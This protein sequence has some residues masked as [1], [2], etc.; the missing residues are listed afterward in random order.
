MSFSLCFQQRV[1]LKALIFTIDRDSHWKLIMLSLCYGEMTPVSSSCW[2]ARFNGGGGVL[3]MNIKGPHTSS[4]PWLWRFGKWD[5]ELLGQIYSDTQC[6]GTGQYF[7]NKE[8]VLGG[9][10][11]TSTGSTPLVISPL[12]G[13]YSPP[14]LLSVLG[15][16]KC[17]KMEFTLR[18]ERSFYRPNGS[19]ATTTKF[20]RWWHNLP[21]DC[22]LV[23]K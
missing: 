15:R 22:I 5:Y 19:P 23:G 16:R 11:I 9:P 18:G 7:C 8:F 4:F 21:W 6:T 10:G 3:W 12:W 14:R 2:K 20:I 17:L 1:G 13:L